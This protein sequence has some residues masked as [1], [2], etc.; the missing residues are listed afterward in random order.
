M[1][2]ELGTTGKARYN[3][4]QLAL[5]ASLMLGPADISHA[6]EANG[7]SPA[8]PKVA[9]TPV[10]DMPKDDYCANIADLAA[11][12]RYV[13]QMKT[14]EDLEKKID[15]KIVLLE[16]KR[17]ESEA[18]LKKRNDAIKETRQDLVD[19]FSK[20]KPDV[21]AAQFEIL[22]V[23]TSA[24]ILKQLNA[25]VASTILNEMKAPIAAAI[26]VKMAEPVSGV[27][28]DGGT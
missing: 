16:A 10:L 1:N 25:R 8:A 28:L 7:A 5:I 2:V 21:A 17:A 23:E 12:A 3:L 15:Q 19:I 26:T 4:G 9:A 27:K 24:S 14:L 22:D 11:D 13:L 18:F 20:M 6:S